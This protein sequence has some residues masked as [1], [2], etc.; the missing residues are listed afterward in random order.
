MLSIHLSLELRSALFV[1]LGHKDH[2][3]LD[4]FYVLVEDL[5]LDHHINLV[6]WLYHFHFLLE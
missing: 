5:H 4:R 1:L 2:L 3:I 6:L